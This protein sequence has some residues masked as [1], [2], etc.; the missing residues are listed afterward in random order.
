ML[1]A[2]M[3][4]MQEF[5]DVLYARSY[6]LHGCTCTLVW[7][8]MLGSCKCTVVCYAYLSLHLHAWFVHAQFVVGV[9]AMHLRVLLDDS[10]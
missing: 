5:V 10:L 4:L 6:V 9:S 1:I 8:C 2:I 3:T 7:T